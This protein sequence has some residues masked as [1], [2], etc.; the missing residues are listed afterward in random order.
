MQSI[1]KQILNKRSIKSAFTKQV[2]AALVEMGYEETTN[3]RIKCTK[4]NTTFEE[5]GL[6]GFWDFVLFYQIMHKDLPEGMD[7]RC[8]TQHLGSYQDYYYEYAG[9]HGDLI[10]QIKKFNRIVPLVH[11]MTV[12][13]DSAST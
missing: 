7:D 8:H 1:V 5:L 6:F 11:N 10:K 3:L 4:R 13:H 9:Q 2:L 12:T